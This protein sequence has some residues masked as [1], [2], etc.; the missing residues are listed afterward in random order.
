KQHPGVDLILDV[1]NKKQVLESLEHNEVD[2]SLV[3]VLPDA[4]QIEKVELLPNALYMM[5]NASQTFDKKKY[6]VS[7]L[8][9]LAVIYREEGSGTRYIMEKFIENNNLKVPKKVEL[10]GNEA[11]KQAVLAGLGC[12]IMPLI[13]AKNEINSGSLQIVPV[14]GLPI[15]SNWN[16]IWLKGKKFSPVAH[17]YLQF[18]QN[19]KERIIADSFQWI[20]EK[21]NNGM[22]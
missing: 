21:D 18:I 9:E 20:K 8:E 3:S 2:F 15:K 7:L 6:D 16:L 1:T 5:V 4:I 22:K 14:K 13:G 19:E 10:T 17:A 12:S 11:V